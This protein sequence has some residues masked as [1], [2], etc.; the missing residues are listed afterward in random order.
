[1]SA[2]TECADAG[3]IIAEAA[4][5]MEGPNCD[6]SELHV[7]PPFFGIVRL[8]GDWPRTI[9]YDYGEP[10]PE[11]FPDAAGR[12]EVLADKRFAFGIANRVYAISR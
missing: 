6:T 11:L 2:P 10:P 5:A 3:N 4:L 12:R 8:L 9:I 1:M 7:T